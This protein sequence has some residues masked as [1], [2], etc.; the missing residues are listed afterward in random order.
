VPSNKSRR[1][2]PDDPGN[3]RVINRIEV[4]PDHPSSSAYQFQEEVEHV[5]GPP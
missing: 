5:Q 2:P 4:V 1:Q 3:L